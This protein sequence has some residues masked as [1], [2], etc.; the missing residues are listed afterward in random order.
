MLRLRNSDRERIC[1][2]AEE[3]YP[4][5]CCGVLLGK[6]EGDTRLVVET[7]RCRN[8]RNDSPE[9][10][11]EIGPTEVAR[12]LRDARA[13]GLDIIGFYHSHPDHTALWSRTDFEEAYWLG[14]SYV[15]TSVA[16]GKAQVTRSYALSGD[17]LETKAFVPE[18][19]LADF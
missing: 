13:R 11:Y 14:C 15:I 17:S 10:R 19:I 4:Y 18:K 2:H 16:Q 3:E 6:V 9:C 12:A 8:I 5:E 7:V 1:L